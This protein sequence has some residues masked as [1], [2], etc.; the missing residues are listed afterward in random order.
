VIR[1][2]RAS[3]CVVEMSP[4]ALRVCDDGVGL[5]PAPPDGL[6]GHG[7]AGLRQRVEHAGAAF[8]IGPGTGGKGCE[9]LVKVPS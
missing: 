5:P 6:E 2:S 1:H 9:V 7:L 8:H 3:R 4:Q